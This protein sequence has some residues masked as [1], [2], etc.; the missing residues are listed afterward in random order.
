[1]HKKYKLFIFQS[2]VLTGDYFGKLVAFSSFEESQVDFFLSIQDLLA[3][4]LLFHR[5]IGILL[6]MYRGDK[7]KTVVS[8]ARVCF[9]V[10]FT[11]IVP[12]TFTYTEGRHT[13]R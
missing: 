1:M 5:F 11:K 2:V 10:I 12:E 9:F 7:K 4:A 3:V 8:Q 13:T 6:H